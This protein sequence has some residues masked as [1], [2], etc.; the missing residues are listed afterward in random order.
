MKMLS[1]L[2]L[3][4]SW[5]L[6]LLAT[7]L[8]ADM[9]DIPPPILIA[10]AR[11]VVLARVVTAGQ[12]QE[13]NVVSR[14]G[15][16]ITGW[17]RTYQVRVTEDLQRPAL[18]ETARV[19]ML[20]FIT[21]AAAPPPPVTEGQPLVFGSGAAWPVLEVNKEYLLLLES[22]QDG[23]GL[24]LPTHFS[25]YRPANDAM[26]QKVRTIANP[27][28]WPWGKAVDGLQLL[29]WPEA[30][31]AHVAANDESLCYLPTVAALRNV[32]KVPIQ[33]NLYG[34]DKPLR[35]VFTNDATGTKVGTRWYDHLDAARTYDPQTESVDIAPGEIL[36]IGPDGKAPFGLG[37]DLP[38]A[39][40]NWTITATYTSVRVKD[41]AVDRASP[42]ALR[43]LWKGTLESGPVKLV[44]PPP[45]PAW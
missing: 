3:L 12:P 15:M 32:S 11:R 9:V 28:T 20:T 29:F 18:M 24:F 4:T 27:G 26:V 2:C 42:W 1:L 44:T 14:T 38:L 41:T 40:G 7:P 25:N 45:K 10:Q 17:W 34:G 43:P 30:G 37:L 33:V 36:W 5:L 6:C 23:K 31:Y 35:A 22:R 13:I 21:P 39:Q 16:A 8:L 19:E